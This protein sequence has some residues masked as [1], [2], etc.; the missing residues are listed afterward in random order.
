MKNRWLV[1]A[2]LIGALLAPVLPVRAEDG[3][4]A[5]P[6]PGAALCL[7][8]AYLNSPGDCLPLGPSQT[9]T[10][11]A[12]KGLTYPP[13]PL[14]AA[15]PPRDL[16]RS[17]VNIAKINLDATEPANLYATLDDAVA[18]NNP[19]RQ[20]SPG[21]GLRYVSYVQEARVN[22]KAFVQLKT[23]EWMRASPA[24]PSSYFQGLLFQKTPA[25]SFG[26]VID[27]IRARSS[28]SY[29]APEAGDLIAQN[30]VVQIYDIVQAEN[31]E[32]YMIGQDQWVPWQKARPAHVD[33][34]PP[35]GVTS[36]RWIKVDL[37]NQVLT[38]YEN[39]QL[40]FATMVASGGEPFYT[41]PGLFKIYKK[42]PLETMSGAFEAGRTDFYY[43]ED[44]PWTMYFDQAR[45]LHGA[46]WRPWFGMPGTHGCVNLSIGDAAWLYQWANEGDPVYVWDP[47]GKTPTDPKLYTEG[48]A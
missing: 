21:A 40:I 11:L 10:E 23:G 15:N 48:G 38:V 4:A 35:P 30:T 24:A 42:K 14:P 7:P 37:Y 2:I 44:V 45:A 19:T 29:N 43:L 17:P 28:P 5:E 3:K 16:T 13:R 46:Y 31:M 25:T 9:L 22:G 36:N 47:S 26:W 34:A 12:K 18:G 33:T 27:R 8:D 41:R 6:Y 32:W 1:L 39:H 20:I